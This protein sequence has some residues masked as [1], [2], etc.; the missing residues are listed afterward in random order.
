[1][2]VLGGGIGRLR[3]RLRL[4]ASTVAATVFAA[5]YSQWSRV[6]QARID[7]RQTLEESSSSGTVLGLG[8]CVRVC[9][10]VCAYACV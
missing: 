6:K 7:E 8:V 5:E 9:V 10:C 4:R 1:M 2:A 3:L